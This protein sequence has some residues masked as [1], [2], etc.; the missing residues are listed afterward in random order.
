MPPRRIGGFFELETGTRDEPPHAGALALSNGRAC[1]YVILDEVRPRRVYLPFY[2]CDA[3]LA[4]FSALRIEVEF[5]AVDDALDPMRA[6]PQPTRC[7]P[8]ELF[9][10]QALGIDDRQRYGQQAIV[11]DTHAFYE[12]GYDGVVV[13]FRPKGFRRTDGGYLYTPPAAATVSRT[14]TS[15]RSNGRTAYRLKM[16]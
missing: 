8:H 13:Q 5:Y 4:P 14:G 6:P 2:C 9:R 15:G 1:L 10:P 12:T 11:D 7:S 16:R 3:V